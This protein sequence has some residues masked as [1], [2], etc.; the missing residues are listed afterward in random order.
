MANSPHS[1][2]FDV[3]VIGL[4][5]AGLTAAQYAARA[6]LSVAAF[7]KISPGGQM[8]GAEHLDNYPGFANGTD[9]FALA[10]EMSEQAKR[11]GAQIISEEVA[12]LDAAAAPKRIVSAAGETYEAD[13]VIVATGSGPRRLGLD[14]E[15]DLVG[16]GVSY[17]ATCDGGFFK[18]RSV[19]VVGGGN[20]AVGDAIYL[21]RIAERVHLVHRR[22]ALRADAVYSH[23]LADI[24]NLEFH[25]GFEVR[26]LLETDGA[27]SGIVIES[28]DDADR[29]ESSAP[30]ASAAPSA[31][32]ASAREHLAVDALFVAVGSAP[33]AGLLEGSGVET[34][35]AGYIS[36]DES[37]VTNIPGLFVAGD[38][39]AKP[40]RQV[41]TATSD[42]AN[43]AMS[44]FEYLSVDR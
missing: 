18:G 19:A 17:C 36:A 42:G 7:E 21:S 14:R 1:K 33:N 22:E 27:L 2:H 24:P 39:R 37:G 5:P 40:L 38:L 26:E 4:G 25:G 11:F 28:V 31:S 23:T 16:R 34:D 6:G 12:S 32:A 20:T 44:A 41:V 3:V 13:A 8:T 10:Y 43:A 9:P 15:D 30:A 35:A 29:G